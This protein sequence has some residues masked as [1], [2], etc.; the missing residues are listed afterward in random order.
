LG[1]VFKILERHHLAGGIAGRIEDDPLGTICNQAVKCPKLKE[2]LFSSTR[3]TGTG[4]PPATSIMA[5]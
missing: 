5:G 2:K 3:G 4:M 1:D